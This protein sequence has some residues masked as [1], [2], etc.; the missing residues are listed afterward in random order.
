MILS[1]PLFEA[2]LLLCD[3]SECETVESICSMFKLQITAFIIFQ[4]VSSGVWAPQAL[5]FTAGS[6]APLGAGESSSELPC[7]PL[8]A[9]GERVYLSHTVF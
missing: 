9:A 6:E 1:F 7:P 4:S 8:G 2:H 5:A 3:V